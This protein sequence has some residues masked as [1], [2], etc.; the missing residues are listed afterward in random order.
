MLILISFELKPHGAYSTKNNKRK[1]V[2]ICIASSHLLQFNRR[3]RTKAS[4]DTDQSKIIF[5][6]F[7][8]S[9]PGLHK[10]PSAEKNMNGQ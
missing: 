2:K 1:A 9:G 10:F 4:G 7:D 6:C 5:L 3:N 8:E